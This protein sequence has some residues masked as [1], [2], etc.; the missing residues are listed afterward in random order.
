MVF[1]YNFSMAWIKISK[2]AYAHNINTLAKIASLK[3]LCVVLKDDAYGHGLVQIARLA[4]ELGV[5]KAVVRNLSEAMAIKEYFSLILALDPSDANDEL[6]ENIA[7][8]ANSM[9][10]LQSHAHQALHLKV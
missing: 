4:S 2:T 3:R 9:Q 1:V 5:Q 6:P 10:D 8:A 7:L